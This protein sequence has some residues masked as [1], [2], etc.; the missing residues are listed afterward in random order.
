MT[1]SSSTKGLKGLLGPTEGHWLLLGLLPKKHVPNPGFFAA[2]Y[3]IQYNSE[4]E[5]SELKATLEKFAG[6]NKNQIN[7]GLTGTIQGQKYPG[8]NKSWASQMVLLD[9]KE[10]NIV[11]GG[12]R[13]SCIR[14]T[15]AT[16]DGIWIKCTAAPPY[17]YD[18]KKPFNFANL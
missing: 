16:L 8:N 13:I 17:K 3:E 14:A 15:E 12:G 9:N 1:P 6:H 5:Y 2:A 10:V 4:A 18:Y 7:I 11:N